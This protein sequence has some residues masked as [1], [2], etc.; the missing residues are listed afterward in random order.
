MRAIARRAARLALAA[1][2]AAGLLACGED[3]EAMAAERAAMAPVDHDAVARL[4]PATQVE[5][6]Q[7]VGE[8]VDWITLVHGHARAEDV[9]EGFAAF[10]RARFDPQARYEIREAGAPP[11]VY[12]RE[13]FIAFFAETAPRVTVVDRLPGLL[14]FTGHAVDPDSGR[15]TVT[16]RNT[17]LARLLFAHRPAAP[18]GNMARQAWT[19]VRDPLPAGGHGPWRLLEWLDWPQMFAM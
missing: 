19:F 10:V 2:L 5:L 7:L 17:V 8:I 6:R 1:V 9:P 18:Q 14:V 4:D 12:D 13:A 15:E 16:A 11:E 3:T